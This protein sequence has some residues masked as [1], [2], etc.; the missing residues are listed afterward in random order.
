MYLLGPLCVLLLVGIGHT[1][2]A[3]GHDPGDLPELDAGVLVH[4]D[5]PHVGRE[6]DVGRDQLLPVELL[7]AWRL[8]TVH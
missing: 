3:L 7:A 8:Q 6:E 2:P 1:P 4:R 5:L